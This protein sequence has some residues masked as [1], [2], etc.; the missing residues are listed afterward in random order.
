MCVCVVKAGSIEVNT[1]TDWIWSPSSW[2]I[3][4][5]GWNCWGCRVK[6][7]M[8]QQSKHHTRKQKYDTQPTPPLTDPILNTPLS[9]FTA[10]H[11]YTLV[12]ANTS[13]LLG[14]L[15]PLCRLSASAAFC[16]SVRLSLSSHLS[17]APRKFP[18]GF[19]NGSLSHNPTCCVPPRSDRCCSSGCASHSPTCQAS[20]Y[21]A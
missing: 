7:R 11:T 17:A 15:T 13:D 4:M 6:G 21:S 14:L 2:G 5:A 18:H 10:A 3:S 16:P 12:A 19:V 9:C 20:F 8:C 1:A